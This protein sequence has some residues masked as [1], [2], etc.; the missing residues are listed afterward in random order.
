MLDPKKIPKYS[1]AELEGALQELSQQRKAI[2]ELGVVI[3]ARMDEIAAEAKATK[4]VADMSPA[5]Q[6][7][8]K[9]LIESAR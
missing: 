6:A 4:L 2:H 8:V 1:Y 7:A 5:E 3:T 9:E